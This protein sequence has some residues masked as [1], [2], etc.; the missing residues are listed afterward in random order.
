MKKGLKIS[1]ALATALIIPFTVGCGDNKP[2]ET[3]VNKDAEITQETETIFKTT[4]TE[5]DLAE[6]K[7]YSARMHVE[8]GQVAQNLN[9][10][11]ITFAMSYWILDENKI[12]EL[13]DE[14]FISDNEQISKAQ[15]DFIAGFSSLENKFANKNNYNYEGNLLKQKELDKSEVAQYLAGFIINNLM[16]EGGAIEIADNTD[17]NAEEKEVQK[18]YSMDLRTDSINNLIDNLYDLEP[19]EDEG[20]GKLTQDNFKLYNLDIIYDQEV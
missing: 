20:A 16:L 11:E 3:E 17:I 18:G 2:N 7:E 9:E 6:V 5:E 1:L 15:Q 4:I 13:F 14:D 8:G 19:S 12:N 10:Q